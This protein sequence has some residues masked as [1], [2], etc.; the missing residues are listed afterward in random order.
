MVP[1]PAHPPVRGIRLCHFN[2]G[3]VGI[4]IWNRQLVTHSS[5]PCEGSEFYIVLLIRR[6][7]RRLCRHNNF[8]HRYCDPQFGEELL[9]EC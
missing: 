5:T 8:F 1:S 2:F 7:L 9:S 4:L 3:T 6:I